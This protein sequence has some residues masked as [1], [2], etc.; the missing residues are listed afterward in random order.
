[1]WS[2]HP[3]SFAGLPPSIR[4]TL[5]GLTDHDLWVEYK[6]NKAKY[7]AQSPMFRYVMT[8]INARAMP[9]AVPRS[10]RLEAW[11][12]GRMQA[13]TTPHSRSFA[14]FRATWKRR[15]QAAAVPVTLPAIMRRMRPAGVP[16]ATC[17]TATKGRCS[18]N[19]ATWR[20]WR[21]GLAAAML[22]H[23]LGGPSAEHWLC[24][25]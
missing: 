13:S 11:L 4:P 18:L 15:A 10:L 19:G 17:R 5:A 12:M 6:A 25:P 23:R 1:M 3:R 24:N 8:S 7:G 21:R 16:R 9:C 2:H 20:M 22:M 14:T